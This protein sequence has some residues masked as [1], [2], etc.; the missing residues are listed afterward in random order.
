MTEIKQST[1]RCP[2]CRRLESKLL[3]ANNIIEK[4]IIDRTT[5]GKALIN[6]SDSNKIIHYDMVGKTV[7]IFQEQTIDEKEQA[8]GQRII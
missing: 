7:Q 8:K 3:K 2:N 5:T 4:S 6:D 1:S